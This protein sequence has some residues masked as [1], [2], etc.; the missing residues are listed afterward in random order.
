M[1]AQ[2]YGAHVEEAGTTEVQQ[3][4]QDLGGN[5]CHFCR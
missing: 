5:S 3:I 2:S 4:S 1:S